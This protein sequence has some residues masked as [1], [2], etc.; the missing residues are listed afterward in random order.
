MRVWGVG[1]K[2]WGL[3]CRVQ[4]SCRPK[5]SIE[6]ATT[7]K[8]SARVEAWDFKSMGPK[9]K[10]SQ[11]PCIIMA[12]GMSNRTQIETGNCLGLYSR[13]LQNCTAS[14]LWLHNSCPQHA[15]ILG[16]ACGSSCQFAK[17]FRCQLSSCGFTYLS[18]LHYAFIC[19]SSH[20]NSRQTTLN[21]KLRGTWK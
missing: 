7:F 10:W 17:R 3:G 16:E 6:P 1:F 11:I 20:Y 19:L 4:V 2:V 5:G 8:K 13:G 18:T 14:G 9:I 12:S 15:M 21:P